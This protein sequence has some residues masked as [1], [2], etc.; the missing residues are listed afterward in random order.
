MIQIIKPNHQDGTYH[1]IDDYSF[2]EWELEKKWR[3]EAE[4]RIKILD[5]GIKSGRERGKDMSGFY[6]DGWNDAV[7]FIN[8]S[9]MGS[10][11]NDL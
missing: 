8:Q 11:E 5:S 1:E 4:A 2:I 7:A 9:I 10:Q 6:G 3:L